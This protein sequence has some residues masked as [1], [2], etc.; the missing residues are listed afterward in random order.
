MKFTTS[1]TL[2]VCCA[3][4][5][6]VALYT[7]RPKRRPPLRTTRARS[8]RSGR[9]TRAGTI[10]CWAPPRLRAGCSGRAGRF[11]RVGRCRLEGAGRRPDHDG[12]RPDLEPRHHTRVVD[13][14]LRQVDVQAGQG[15]LPP[16]LG[17]RS[18]G[19]LRRRRRL[20]Q[21]RPRGHE[22]VPARRHHR[23]PGRAPDHLRLRGRVGTGRGHA[24]RPEVREPVRPRR[25]RRL[26][27]PHDDH[28]RRARR[29]RRIRAQQRRH[30][31][32]H[33]PAGASAPE[34]I[35]TSRC[36]SPGTTSPTCRRARPTSRPCSSSSITWSSRTSSSTSRT[37]S[38]RD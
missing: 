8:T 28:L 10:W 15:G 37:S 34:T 30:G 33:E 36:T 14:R 35:P 7:S 19:F 24:E 13:R 26:A 3:A 21:R 9:A 6:L 31:L 23:R 25:L 1:R 22:R 12:A 2:A 5:F 17:R 32:Q 16:P 29:P 4:A 38:R 18:P 27:L 20:H 11:V